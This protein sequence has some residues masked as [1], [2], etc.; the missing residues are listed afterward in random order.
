MDID[1]P[2]GPWIAAVVDYLQEHAAGAFDG[3]SYFIGALVEGIEDALIWVP[4]WI[5][6]LALVGIATWR[7]G[8]R[9]GLFALA[10]MILLFGMDLWRETMQTFALIASSTVVSL[11]IGIPLGIWASRSDKVETAVRPILDLMQTLPPF[12]YLIPAAMF[13]GIG[14]VPGALATIIFSMPPAVRLTNLGIRQVPK[15]IVEAGLA[16]GCT[17]RQLLLRVQVPNAMPSIMAGVNQTIMLALSMVVIASMIGAGGLG[18]TVLTGIQRLDVGLGFEGGLGV[19]ILAVLLDRVMQSFGRNRGE[20][21]NPL[22]RLRA[23]IS[24]PDTDGERTASGR[25]ARSA[26]D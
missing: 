26:G 7:V 24:R 5:I 23:L 20:T 13:F 16:F 9:F 10:S 18:N 1:I 22:G 11:A 2:I 17:D 21:V 4:P 19:V 3:I 6:A 15:E 25:V 12:V 8:W 14:K